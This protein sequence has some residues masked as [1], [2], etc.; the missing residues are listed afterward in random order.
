[1]GPMDPSKAPK[2]TI[3]AEFSADSLEK[4]RKEKRVIQNA[5]HASDSPDELEREFSIWKKYFD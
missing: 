1:M 3:R 5:I 4:S 2:G